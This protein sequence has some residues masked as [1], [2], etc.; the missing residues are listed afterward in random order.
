MAS[1]TFVDIQGLKF[2]DDKFILKEISCITGQIEYH[3]IVKSPFIFSNLNKKFQLQAKWLSKCYHGIDWSNGNFHIRQ[4]K[5]HLRELLQDQPIFV[6]GIEKTNWLRQLFPEIRF[7]V[8]DL[9]TEH[10]CDLKIS[11][12]HSDKKW[13]EQCSFH[14][15]CEHHYQCARVNALAIQNWYNDNV[16]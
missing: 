8:Y 11:N 6:K 2:S 3:A 12:F 15:N 13:E 16:L 9:D 14:M 1:A 7:E 10:G 5:N 4:V